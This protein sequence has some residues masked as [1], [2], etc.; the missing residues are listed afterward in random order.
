MYS[1][2]YTMVIVKGKNKTFSL[3]SE[4]CPNTLCQVVE[5]FRDNNCYLLLASCKQSRATIVGWVLKHNLSP[6]RLMI[7]TVQV[8]LKISR[9]SK[10]LRRGKERSGSL[11]NGDG[12]GQA[13][14]GRRV[15]Q[16]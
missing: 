8:T 7:S 11:S 10:A 1:T 16:A 3:L 14:L 6:K 5:H 12:A 2:S 9:H 13:P 4:A 15:A